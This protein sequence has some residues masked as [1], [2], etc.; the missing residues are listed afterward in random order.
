[1]RL[2]RFFKDNEE[3][4][5]DPDEFYI[6][7]SWNPS[8]ADL[9]LENYLSLLE[10]EV[11]AVS[12]GGKNFP[13]LSFEECEALKELTSD[14]SIVIKEADKGSAVVVWD[15]EDYVAKAIGN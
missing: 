10:K 5:Y 12:P 4:D 13:H 1:M 8:R 3:N 14:R 11:L 6:K 15:R 2:K 7:S 9:I